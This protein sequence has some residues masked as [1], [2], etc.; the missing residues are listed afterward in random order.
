LFAIHNTATLAVSSSHDLQSNSNH[1]RENKFPRFQAPHRVS[2][3]V[4]HHYSRFL[5]GNVM[6]KPTGKCSL[7]KITFG[8][9]ESDDKSEFF[10][11]S[12]K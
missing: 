7:E 10:T 8:V 2:G 9:I 4:G 1:L 3:E 5:T 12:G 6:R 11:N